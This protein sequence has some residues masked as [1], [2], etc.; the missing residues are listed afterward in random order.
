MAR[1]E[2]KRL[3]VELLCR[4][5]KLDETAIGF[6]KRS[7]GFPFSING[8]LVNAPFYYEGFKRN[9]H[10]YVKDSPFVLSRRNGVWHLYQEDIP[11]VD[12]EVSPSPAF[13]RQRTSDG[14]EMR[15]IAPLCGDD[16]L[17]TGV[18]QVCDFWKRGAGCKFCDIP[19]NTYYE[20]RLARKTPL[21]LLEV[22]EAG[23]REGRIRRVLLS[24]GAHENGDRGV[25]AILDADMAV[26]EAFEL[27]IQVELLPPNTRDIWRLAEYADSFNTNI[28]VFDP[29][30]RARLMP[31]KGD[32]KLEE[33]YRVLEDAVDA[34]GENQVQSVVIVGL[35]GGKTLL[36]GSE[37][38]ASIGVFPSLTPFRPTAKTDMEEASPPDPTW[39][40]KLYLSV[41]EMINTYGLKP[42][43]NLGCER[44][45]GCG[46]LREYAV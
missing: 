33:Y 36:E 39:V 29:A 38:L 16:C 12:V 32:I 28:E 30:M 26:K 41:G 35:E 34:F 15:R 44:C 40:E 43:K 10:P 22:V 6:F 3:K 4:G 37:R 18:V 45:G 24:M 8:S 19:L 21:Q 5:V 20:K 31:G 13:Y 25:T 42:E 14:I 1:L 46:A 7:M 23:V 9:R 11:L 27:A 2:L 17:L